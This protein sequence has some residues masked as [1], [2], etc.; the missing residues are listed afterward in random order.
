MLLYSGKPELVLQYSTDNETGVVTP[1]VLPSNLVTS[2]PPSY[3]GDYSRCLAH[4]AMQYCLLSADVNTGGAFGMTALLGLCRPS[5]CDEAAITESVAQMTDEIGFK[6]WQLKCHDQA[7]AHF[8][9]G[10]TVGQIL[11]LG[12]CL[13]FVLLV[14]SGTCIELKQGQSEDAS[15]RFPWSLMRHFSLAR[16]CSSWAK[17]RAD[18]PEEPFGSLDGLRV[19]S[20]VWV[21]LGHTALWPLFSIQ[22]ENVS[23]VFPPHGRLSTPG[24]QI[25]PAAFF[26]VDTFFWISGFLGDRA[27]RSRLE[28]SNYIATVKGFFCGLYPLA[29][30]SRW[31]RLTPVYLFVL[32]FSNTL[33]RRAGG[34]G[35]VWN[36]ARTCLSSI[37]HPHCYKYWWANMFYINNIVDKLPIGPVGQGGDYCMAWSWYLA[38]D[39]QM[40]LVLPLLL[41]LR[42]RIGN[43]AGWVCLASLAIAG[44]ARACW[45]IVGNNF[46]S[47]PIFGGLEFFHVVYQDTLS[48]CQ[49]FLVGVGMSWLF[50][51]LAEGKRQD[52]SRSMV[53][54]DTPPQSR[55]APLV[56]GPLST[57]FVSLPSKS[58]RNA[59]LRAAGLQIL[60]VVL[61]L[62]MVMLPV[63]R[64]QC[65]SLAGC[66][67]QDSNPWPQ[68]LNVL[69]GCF[70]HGI[71]AI[72]LSL[73]FLPTFLKHPGFAWVDLLLNA[74]GA[75][76]R[77]QK[78]TFIVYLVHPLVLTYVF[79][80]LNTAVEYHDVT[81]LINYIAVVF[82]SFVIA[83]ATWL[84]VE[85]PLA[86]LSAV[87]LGRLVG[88]SK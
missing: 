78:L 41:I 34:D 56:E 48:R 87:L 54:L 44:V 23:K 80:Q 65:E 24:F 84:L 37:E 5:E 10:L 3:L 43:R 59:L 64:N 83:M 68:W 55:Q 66:L 53:F 62:T 76:Q 32:V 58:S 12:A 77:L 79:C 45:L 81:L 42:K 75:W 51:Y 46:V 28:R 67:N 22:Y 19:I 20:T 74:D 71:W 30:F 40:F 26:A 73:L 33:F 17:V 35:L 60:A 8:E 31:L 1:Q 39:M 63:T 38:C 70:S 82:L 85:K 47:D 21:V 15:T 50:D 4:P 69:Y 11:A 25:V 49:P 6:D 27:L 9:S 14:I 57:S 88:G 86:N 61:M 36:S 13:V 18:N 29:V 7:K 72:G 52:L 16:N 2:T